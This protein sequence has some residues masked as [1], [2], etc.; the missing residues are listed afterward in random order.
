MAIG[1]GNENYVMQVSINPNDPSVLASVCSDKTIKF[2]RLGEEKVVR[3][4]E[5]VNCVEFCKEDGKML[6]GSDETSIKVWKERKEK[7]LRTLSGHHHNVT[8]VSQHKHL[9]KVLNYEMG[10]AWS[11]C[12]GEETVAIGWRF[13][14]RRV[15]T[16]L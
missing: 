3:I 16:E 2:W 12:G 8:A 7:C 13:W 11:L 4:L 15:E 6:S 5:G 10:R 14:S 9:E 1:A